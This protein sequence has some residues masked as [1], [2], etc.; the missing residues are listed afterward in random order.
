MCVC[1]CLFTGCLPVCV[2]VFSLPNLASCEAR[3]ASGSSSIDSAWNDNS[4]FERERRGKVTF[5]TATKKC[6]ARIPGWMRMEIMDAQESFANRD[7]SCLLCYT[8]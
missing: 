4:Y 7:L 5:A 1:D 8:R 6:R 3:E 2:C